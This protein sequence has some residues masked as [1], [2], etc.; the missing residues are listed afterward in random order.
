MLRGV[1]KKAVFVACSLLIG[2]SSN[3]AA[4]FVDVSGVFHFRGLASANTAGLLPGATQQ[5]GAVS[6]VPSGFPETLGGAR[7]PGSTCMDPSCLDAPL[8]FSPRPGGQQDTYRGVVD[9]DASRTGSWGLFFL[10]GG[11]LS[12]PFQTPSI[13][14]VAEMPFATDVSVSGTGTSP[15]IEWTIPEDVIAGRGLNVDYVNIAV[16]DLLADRM[17]GPTA[18]VIF[19]GGALDPSTTSFTIPEGVLDPDGYYSIQLSLNDTRDGTGRLSQIQ[20]SST[21]LFNFKPSVTDMTGGA[22]VIIPI[23]DPGS[24]NPYFQFETQV[25][26]GDI[27]FIDPLIAIGYD[28]VIGAG[29]PFF[30]SVVLP[31]VG[32]NLFELW[33]WDGIEYVLTDIL[34][35]GVEYAFAAGGVDRFRILGI[36]ALAAL[37]PNDAAAFVTG[38]TFTDDGRFT[39]T[40]TPIT[41]FVPE[42]A[43]I[44][45]LTLGLAGVG[46]QRR[47]QIKA[48]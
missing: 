47:K 44:A 32:D 23:V 15:T 17:G 1:K 8:L 30:N 46:F 11:D 29:D 38:L 12:G 13:D 40:M 34:T 2:W 28:Y 21:G 48:A 33:L 3:A 26:A 7:A 16:R 18:P 10:N 43:S 25:T 14:G 39:G 37:D 31:E 41:E 27:V 4:T 6:V 19:N 5:I 22:E 45:L 36:E 35:A 42:P 9:Y 24:G 20:S